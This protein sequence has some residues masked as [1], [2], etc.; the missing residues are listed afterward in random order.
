MAKHVAP[1]QVLQLV[2]DLVGCLPDLPLL[3]VYGIPEVLVSLDDGLHD[4]L[5]LADHVKGRRVLADVVDRGT[6][7]HSELL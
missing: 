1:A 3:L 4:E 7:G 2:L 5:A 6:L